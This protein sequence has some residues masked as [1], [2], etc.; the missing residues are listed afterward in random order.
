MR[1]CLVAG[2]LAVL[3]VAFGPSAHALQPVLQR[4]YDANVSGAN[5]AEVTL[6][7]SNVA[8]ST[9]GLVFKLPVDDN[10]F[11]QP[12]YVPNVAISGQGTHN[13]V[14]VA[15]MSDSLYAFDA[16]T[17]AK[18]W[19]DNFASSVGAT[20]VA[21]AKFAFAGNRNVVGN[22]GI[23]S[24]PVIDPSTNI[25]YLVACTLESGTMVYRLHAVDITSGDE[26]IV[27]GGTVISGS[28]SGVA[29]DAPHQ[30]QRVSLVL[31]GNYVVFG[32]GALEEEASNPGYS[33]WVMA[34]NKMTLAQSGIFS[35]ITTGTGTLGGGVWQ[36]GRPP[37]VDSSGY[38]YV[39]VGNG[40][41]PGT[42][43]GDSNSPW[44]G[45]S[46]FNESALKL[47]P[48]S[49]LSLVDWFTPSNWSAM[50]EEDLDFTSSGPMLIPGT[51][52]IAGGGKTG[53]LY[54]LN[55]AN[56]GK[57]SATD[58][59]VVQE[60]TV[61]SDEIR[62][63]PVYWQ[64]TANGSPLLYNWG[65]GDTLNAYAFNGT[66]FTTTPSAQG[67][68]S[69]VWPGGIL[70]LS[71][72]GNTPGSGVLWATIATSGD[73]ENNPPVP[74]ALYAF[75]ANDVATE[76]WN[77]TLNSAR[78]NFGNFAK[79]VP[80]L[81]ANGRVYVATQSNQ[82]AVYGLL[83]SGSPAATPT[84]S[85]VAGTYIGTQS[86]TLLDT[87]P[88]AVIHYTTNGTT[89]TTSSATFN[90]STPIA[91]SSSETIEAIAVASGYTTSAVGSAAYTIS[92][93]STTVVNDPTGFSS[94][95]GLGL[96]GGA[97]V[98]GG[99]LELTDGG[100]E[101]AHAVWYATPV[102]VQNFTTDFNFQ[103]TPAST[104]IGDGFT[105]T[106]QNAAAG[107][108]TVG[109]GGGDLGYAGIGSSVAVKFD[110]YNNAGEGTDSTGFYTDGAVPTVPAVDMTASGVNLH[111]GDILHAHI[112]YDGTTLTLTL[113]DTVTNASFT[114][115]KVINI[116]TT[117][118]GNTAYAGF[119]AGDWSLTSTQKILNWTYV[120]N[121]ATPVAATPTFSP[122]AGTYSG[123]QSVTLLDATP[124]AVMYYTTNGTTPTT[125]SAM[126]NPSTPIAVSS[127]ETIEAIAV[128]SGYTTSAVGSASYTISGSSPAA[129]PTFSPV[130]G[131]YSGAQSVT[132]LDATPGAV[133]YYTTN[134]T[135]PTT[136]SV[137]FNPSTPI[138]VS[139][140]ET[141]EAIAVASGYTTSAVGS[142]AYTISGS[143]TTVVNDPTGFSSSTGLGLVGGASVTG[144]ALELTDGGS[145]EARAVWYATPV[146]VQNFTT[147]FNFQITPASTYI[148]DGFTFTLQNA[149]AG[150]QAVGTGG[151]D[152]GYAGIGSSV[153][154]KFDLYNN[155][156]EGSDSTGFY[157]DGAVPTVP[158]V[159][160][161]ASGVNLHSGDILH[162][163]ITY[164]GTTL[165][166][167][168]TDTVTNAS[169]T[170]STTTIN[171]PTT[172]GG[173]TAYAGFTAGD[174]SLTSTQKI[175]NWTY[176]VN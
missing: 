84:F 41:S 69:P 3:A 170:T 14:Y 66:N 45:V 140:S 24:T 76:L 90:P 173:N 146:N 54:V 154:V 50:D 46:N 82:V 6:N 172:V 103:I 21:Y 120:V 26:L 32:F 142:A 171:I 132:L 127:S 129:T 161:T 44:N 116:P 169:F 150:V 25:L 107:V 118:G 53:V 139:S 135:T 67:S 136:S 100:S 108:Q 113:T 63:G 36:S 122:V 125:S 83:S 167:T 71:A 97:S 38:V 114:T 105:F 61:T 72:N 89:P 1:N 119:T 81:V 109:T 86:V 156:G 47:N 104:Y 151:G 153:A 130:A 23:L 59:G 33:G 48:A 176:V 49:G 20:P 157:T 57:E 128:A 74:G 152:L 79:F 158:A 60:F 16:D 77:S 52:L 165:T 31:S 29:F 99:A 93:S 37:V 96:V 149:A 155:A 94:S 168:L 102:N 106:L 40:Y 68:I 58:S 141:I 8:V 12:L 160:M 98:T 134:G 51:S 111:S 121:S 22:L 27:A 10:I 145:E 88:G 124:G 35:P 164:D 87:T 144:G 123:A 159:D 75:D 70:T 117:V 7:T 17:G 110:L 148:G 34:Y 162:A 137:M 30:T 15:T 95:T 43:Y 174:W 39:F 80:P 73:A 2:A 4:G 55:T 166:L 101:E 147:D 85:P 115:S 18:L 28:Y 133:M 13:V 131:T 56:L 175:L 112:T 78:D 163:H 143:S 19:S 64:R 42:G 138:A 91:V 65:D 62:G 126:F 11:A 5:L 92:G 9:F